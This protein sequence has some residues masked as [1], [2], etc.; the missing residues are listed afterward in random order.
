MITILQKFVLG[1]IFG[2]VLVGVSFFG[3]SSRARAAACDLGITL[4]E[5][6]Q[7]VKS[8]NVKMTDYQKFGF[9]VSMQTCPTTRWVRVRFKN[10]NEAFHEFSPA[11][12]GVAYSKDFQFG[13]PIEG[14]STYRVEK[15][16]LGTF[17]IGDSDL[18][19]KDLVVNWVKGPTMAPTGNPNGGGTTDPNSPGTSTTAATSSSAPP[20]LS[21][22]QINS[23]VRIKAG[24]SFD[25]V[26]GEFF[27]PLEFKS[28]PELIVRL[29]N[30][31]L[32]LA[33]MLAVI[34]IISG[35]FNLVTAMGTE[36][37]ITKGKQSILW[38]V[39]GLIVC[40]LSF[41]IVAIVQKIITS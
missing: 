36:S 38:A 39:A 1:T 24:Q 21:N 41:S 28:V 23:G 17:S 32:L 19:Q 15:S 10:G 11:E 25:T 40:L 4:L 3:Y 2:L 34:V 9:R 22:E 16:T 35:G 27:N 8:A 31:G 18:G 14:S 13:Q 6:G 30:I 12:Q 20:G 33:A 5:N 7:P 29:I 26:I 37:K